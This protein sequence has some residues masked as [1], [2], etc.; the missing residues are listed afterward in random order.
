LLFTAKVLYSLGIREKHNVKT[1]GDNALAL[2]DP[3]IR[4]ARAITAIADSGETSATHEARAADL[5][6]TSKNEWR[7]MKT[8]IELAGSN[9]C[10][11]MAETAEVNKL[12]GWDRCTPEDYT[13]M[14]LGNVAAVRKVC[15]CL[16]LIHT[17]VAEATEAV[18]NSNEPNFEEELADVVIRVLDLCEGLGIGI[19][20]RIAEKLEKNRT[21]GLRH[22]GKIV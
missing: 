4:R 10:E 1:G 9:L 16:A 13:G 3:T 14:V 7:M 20:A 2:R 21:R 18:R 22:G 15:T 5:L 12:N 19:D 17:E 6:I 8:F 11:L